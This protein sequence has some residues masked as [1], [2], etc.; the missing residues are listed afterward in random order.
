LL[1][2]R[3][4]RFASRGNFACGQ[5]FEFYQGTPSSQALC[6]VLHERKFLRTGKDKVPHGMTLLV[7]RYFQMTKELRRIL[8][9][10]D[11]YG[12]GIAME[13]FSGTL[14]RQGRGRR[15]VKRNISMVSKKPAQQGRFARLPCASQDN[16]GKIVR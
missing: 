11:K 16:G 2:I 14:A 12:R 1:L 8:H 10:I 15:D 4:K 3:G 7:N 6:H 13:K 5:R 9:F